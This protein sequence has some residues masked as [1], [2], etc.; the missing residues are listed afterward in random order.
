M[1]SSHI[2]AGL[3]AA[4][5]L[6]LGALAGCAQIRS[7]LGLDHPPTGPLPAAP[8]SGAFQGIGQLLGPPQASDGT[9]EQV[10][11]PYTRI[12]PGDS[13]LVLDHPG[14]GIVR[15]LRIALTSADPDYLRKI[16]I[17]MYWDTEVDPS[18]EAPLG[19]FF[20]NA[21]ERTPY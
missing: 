15:V 14:P 9:I 10:V 21:F 11:F 7:R 2:R 5:L 12:A 19:D 1:T 6:A 8:S 17:R 3:R 20:G 16:V 18:V 4:S 13:A